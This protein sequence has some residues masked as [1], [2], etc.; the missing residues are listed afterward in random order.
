MSAPAGRGPSDEPV[1]LLVRSV[2]SRIAQA[3]EEL[4][5]CE[6]RATGEGFGYWCSLRPD[7]VMCAFCFGAAQTMAAAGDRD[8]TVAARSASWLGV[9]FFLRAR[10]CSP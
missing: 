5:L 2:T 9:Y 8:V 10:C 6:H 7:V 4:P 3:A 1:Q